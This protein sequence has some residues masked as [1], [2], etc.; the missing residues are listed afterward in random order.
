LSALLTLGVFLVEEKMWPLED[1]GRV[2]E[3]LDD[4]GVTLE[5][6]FRDE[7]GT[8]LDGI[9]HEWR[10]HVLERALRLGYSSRDEDG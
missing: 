2:F 8:D 7:L 9:L 10:E 1:L 5:A 4:H 3:R 6:A